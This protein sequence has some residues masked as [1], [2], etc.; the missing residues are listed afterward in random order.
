MSDYSYK[1]LKCA[2]RIGIYLDIPCNVRVYYL[3][4]FL[5]ARGSFP[6]FLSNPVLC[7]ELL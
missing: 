4:A 3:L 1:M 5:V 7:S 6:T 2:R